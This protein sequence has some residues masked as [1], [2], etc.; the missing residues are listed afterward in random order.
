[1]IG[2]DGSSHYF[3][4]S[5]TGPPQG[6]TIQQPSKPQSARKEEKIMQFLRMM[7]SILESR[8]ETRKRS[9]KF[10]IPIA[11]P[12][13]TRLRLFEDDASIV[14]LQDVWDHYCKERRMEPF[15]PI[16]LQTERLRQLSAVKAGEEFDDKMAKMEIADE[17]AAKLCPDTILKRYLERTMPN[18]TSYWYLRKQITLHMAGFM[19]IS[20]VLQ[21]AKRNPS[22]IMLSRSKGSFFA[23]DVLPNMPGPQDE[24]GRERPVIS[25]DEPVPFRF[26]PNLQTYV[27]PIGIEGPLVSSLLAIARCLTEHP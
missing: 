12:L 6:L 27:T 14:S 7:N 24:P 11:L 21:V 16:T 19:F 17:I 15:D 22:R 9:L 8:I 1:M 13:S 20:Y 4:I 3:A 5:N 23:T 26:T 10:H 18:Q 2:H 25:N